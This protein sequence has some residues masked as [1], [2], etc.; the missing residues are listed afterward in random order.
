MSYL[1]RFFM[2]F[3]AAALGACGVLPAKRE[4]PTVYSPRLH[5]SSPQA[6]TRVP[7][8]LLVETP[9]ANESLDS[10]RILVMPMPGT[11]QIYKGALWSDRAPTLLRALLIEAF[12]RSNRINGV[13][14]FATGLSSD[15]TLAWTLRDFQAE[16]RDGAPVAVVRVGVNL[17]DALNGR[18]VAARTFEASQSASSSAIASVAQAFETALNTLLPQIVEWTLASGSAVRAPV[19]TRN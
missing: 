16:Y 5:W 13:G 8:Q 18:V 2:I 19:P 12:E 4:P 14:S 3:L 1:R 7:F 10:N 11:L 15:F 17:V 6:Q 9:Q